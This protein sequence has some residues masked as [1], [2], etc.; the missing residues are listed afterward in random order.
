MEM[1]MTDETA[2]TDQALAA[3]DALLAQYVVRGASELKEALRVMLA[4]AWVEGRQAGGQE[5]QAVVQRFAA[6]LGL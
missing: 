6:K 4:I 1:G 5:A 2:M 3:A